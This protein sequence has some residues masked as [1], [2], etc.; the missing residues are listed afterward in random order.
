MRYSQ[1]FE[2]APQSTIFGLIK[3]ARAKLGHWAV[4]AIDEW[5][6]SNWT[7]GSL[8]EH[9]A[10]KDEVAEDIETAFAPVRERLPE[11][12]TLYR[13]IILDPAYTSWEKGILSSWS[14]DVRTAELFAGL[15]YGEKW[16][17]RLA[18]VLTD[19]EIAEMVA[20]YERTGFLKTSSYYFIRNKEMPQYYNI[21]SRDKSFLTDGDDLAEKLHSDNDWIKERNE[22]L[23]SKSKVFHEEISRDRVVWITNQLNCKEFIVRR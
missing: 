18:D 4:S 22:G 5:E 2:K 19:A 7:G 3:I 1:L 20:R 11:T 16:K 9:I 6:T 13:G 10:A 8:E 14:S 15:R 12:I 23:K 17:S 21:F